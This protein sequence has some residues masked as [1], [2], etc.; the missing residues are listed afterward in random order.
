M[1]NQA[2]HIAVLRRVVL[3]ISQSVRQ[4]PSFSRVFRLSMHTLLKA[5]KCNFFKNKFLHKLNKV[6]FDK[7]LQFCERMS[8]NLK[9]T[10]FSS[11]N[12][13]SHTNESLTSM[14]LGTDTTINIGPTKT[15]I[16]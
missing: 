2:V 7:R 11:V 9:D 1:V 6:D 8:N 13:C 10:I 12:T 15:L 3:D 14:V 5:Q 16:C 4:L